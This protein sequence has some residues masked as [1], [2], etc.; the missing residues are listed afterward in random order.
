MR[1][2][3]YYDFHKKNKL[4]FEETF[5]KYYTRGYFGKLDK[6]EIKTQQKAWFEKLMYF[7]KD[8]NLFELCMALSS[9][10]NRISREWFSH[11]TGHEIKYETKEKV[12]EIIH[13]YVE[14]GHC[15]INTSKYKG[16][17]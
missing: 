8:K 15:I 17:S 3:E 1:F 16:K 7:T 9:K 4:M 13:E 10:E 5:E 6:K 2:L 12:I 14:N 11:M